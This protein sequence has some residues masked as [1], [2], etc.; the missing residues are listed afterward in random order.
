MWK[1]IEIKKLLA[2]NFTKL[3]AFIYE[4]LNAQ[5]FQLEFIFEK[6]SS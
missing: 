4:K 6:Y 5:P 1:F 2:Y 3:K